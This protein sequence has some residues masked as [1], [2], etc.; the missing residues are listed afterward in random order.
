[1]LLPLDEARARIDVWRFR[2][3]RWIPVP[4]ADALGRISTSRIVV[5]RDL[6][7]RS[8]SAMDGYAVRLANGPSAGPFPVPGRN[9]T[10]LRPGEA[11]PI[12]TGSPL[13]RGANAVVR[14]EATRQ[15]GGELYCSSPVEPGQD[16]V[17]PG[18]FLHRGEV[19][20]E[21]GEPVTPYHLGALIPLG[22]LRI[23]VFDIR[24][25]IL[26][27]GDELRPHD[28]PGRGTTRDAIGP[29][30]QGLLGFARPS[31]LPPV[32]DDPDAVRTAI[33]REVARCDLL[34]TIGGASRGPRDLTKGV[35]G[36]LG[37]TLFEGVTVNVLKRGG[38]AIVEGRP[39]VVLP[40]QITSAVTALHEHGLHI[41]SRLVGRELRR[42]EEVELGEEVAVHHR[43]DTTLLFRLDGGKAFALPWGVARG[44]ALLQARGFAVLAHGHTYPRG[45]RITVQRLTG[46]G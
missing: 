36:E 37:E 14:I 3:L 1:M 43:M 38:V 4:V 13:P 40:G 6:P 20:L 9:P 29:V 15:E 21:R 18:E 11:I 45:T 41:L 19:V 30:V 39:V 17:P 25:A 34:L 12:A 10:T 31:L 28:H 16:I 24:V 8:T 2:P 22:K 46:T 5:A 33:L 42:F 27:I 44:Q 7:P 26:P 23:P 35:L 32:T